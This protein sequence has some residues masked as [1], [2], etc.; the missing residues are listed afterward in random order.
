MPIAQHLERSP[1][2]SAFFAVR[3]AGRTA[4]HWPCFLSISEKHHGH[5]HR[6]RAF[7]GTGE[8][9]DAVS[10]QPAGTGAVRTDPDRPEAG[11]QSGLGGQSSPGL[12]AATPHRSRP[13]DGGCG[14]ALLPG[15]GVGGRGQIPR[16]ADAGDERDL[17]RRQDDR[18]HPA[19]QSQPAHHPAHQPADLGQGGE[20]C[21]TAATTSGVRGRLRRWWRR[22]RR[23]E[24]CRSPARDY[25]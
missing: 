1:L 14:G 13:R 15:K 3:F 2:T 6:S 8:E 11:A 16:L 21:A 19:T 20:V 10:R 25:R 4:H 12:L 24:A 5:C 7:P 23:T 9:L 18:R 17:R 22:R